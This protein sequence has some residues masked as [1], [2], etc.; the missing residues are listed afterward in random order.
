MGVAAALEEIETNKGTLYAPEVV[1][2]CLRL[3]K[4]KGYKM[5]R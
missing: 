5:E 3:F 2:A 1:N 4:E